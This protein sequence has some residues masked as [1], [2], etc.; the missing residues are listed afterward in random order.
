MR[1]NRKSRTTNELIIDEWHRL[2]DPAVGA[3]EL[4]EIQ[5]AIRAH[6]GKGAMKSPAAIARVLADQGA[7]LRHPAVIES[8]ARWREREIENTAG[9]LD[10]SNLAIPLELGGVEAFIRNL[11]KLRQQSERSGDP[12]ALRNVRDT[13]IKARQVA[14]SLARNRTLTEGVRA[15]QSEVAEWLGVWIKTPNLFDDWLELRRRSPD[16]QK[17]FPREAF[18]VQ[19]QA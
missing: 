13:A 4:R 5:R 2:R 12:Q 7:E 6:S 9:D 14:E 11:E 15:E 8:D 17:R 19:R 18:G 10:N 3:R 16:F 1:R